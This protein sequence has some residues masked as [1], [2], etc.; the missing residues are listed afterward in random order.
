VLEITV[1]GPA[2][3]VESGQIADLAMRQRIRAVGGR[4]RT[5]A[6]SAGLRVEVRFPPSVPDIDG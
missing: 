3:K 5:R 6:V 2:R 4:L 1:E